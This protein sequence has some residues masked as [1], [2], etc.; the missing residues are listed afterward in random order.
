M[1]EGRPGTK[2]G[3]EEEMEDALKKDA[4]DMRSWWEAASKG[5]SEITESRLADLT[6]QRVHSGILA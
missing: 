3:H 6:M 2:M 1:H 5:E 4:V